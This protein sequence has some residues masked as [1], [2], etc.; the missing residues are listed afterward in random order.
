[1]GIGIYWQQLAKPL[2][3]S[4]A[5]N[6]LWINILWGVVNLL[7]IYPLDGGQISREVCQ[8]GNPRG[9]IILSLQISVGVAIGMAIFGLIVWESKYTAVMFG[10]LAYS[11]YQALQ[12]YRQHLW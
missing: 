2:L 4:T 11:S 3:Q 12:A 6:F 8:I 1:L 9:G 10:F 5:F 7:P